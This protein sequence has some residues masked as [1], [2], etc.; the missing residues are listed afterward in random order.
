MF[1]ILPKV[2]IAPV[3]W[4]TIACSAVE[5]KI[6]ELMCYNRQNA[7]VERRD[8]RGSVEEYCYRPRDLRKD[9]SSVLPFRS[10]YC[11]DRKARL[12]NGT[13]RADCSDLPTKDQRSQ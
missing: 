11:N 12:R 7:F 5:N 4:D 6:T 8:A 1:H 9:A 2:A 3:S 10:H 13:T